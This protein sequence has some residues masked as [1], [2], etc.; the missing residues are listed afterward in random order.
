M[1]PRGALGTC[2]KTGSHC[3]EAGWGGEQTVPAGPA[4]RRL[5]GNSQSDST[6]IPIAIIYTKSSARRDLEQRLQF[7]GVANYAAK[8][9]C[10]QRTKSLCLGLILKPLPEDAHLFM[11]ADI[12]TVALSWSCPS[13][14]LTTSQGWDLCLRGH[15]RTPAL[16]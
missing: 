2:P 12:Q 1:S 8:Q 5:H 4:E 15:C 10:T 6:S 13:G 9:E 16:C 14:Q 3:Y 7:L 11:K